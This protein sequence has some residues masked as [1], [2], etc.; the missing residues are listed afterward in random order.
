MREDNASSDASLLRGHAWHVYPDPATP[1]A[2]GGESPFNFNP[3][4]SRGPGRPP[5]EPP[6]GVVAFWTVEGKVPALRNQ[7]EGRAYLVL[8]EAPEPPAVAPGWEVEAA[9]LADN[10]ELDQRGGRS[11]RLVRVVQTAETKWGPVQDC[12]FQVDRA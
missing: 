4:E 5:T 1:G 9:R 11:A 2:L 12:E 7:V 10:F 6:P 8:T 3:G